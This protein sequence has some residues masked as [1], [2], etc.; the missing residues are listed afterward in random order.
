[1]FQKCLQVTSSFPMC[2]NQLRL[3]VL[4]ATRETASLYIKNFFLREKVVTLPP[5]VSE[6]PAWYLTTSVWIFFERISLSH[7]L[8]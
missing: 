5:S 3:N 7:T 6:T 4:G 8:A 1:M 2:Y